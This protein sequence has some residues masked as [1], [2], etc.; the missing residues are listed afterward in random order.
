MPFSVRLDQDVVNK[1]TRLAV[2]SHRRVSDVV[3]EAVELYI[4]NA[5]GNREAVVTPYDRMS[6]LVGRVDL[7]PGSRSED[8]SRKAAAI[9][10]EKYRARRAG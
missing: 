4:A 8:T 7:G 6:H 1:L 5:D 10:R 3:R 9:V 2:Q